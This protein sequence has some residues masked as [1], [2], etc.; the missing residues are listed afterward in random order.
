MTTK[1]GTI[2]VGV[3][4]SDQSLRALSWAVEQCAAEHRTLTLVHAVHVVSPAYLDAAIVYQP[5]AETLL[6]AE[7]QQVLDAAAAE[8]ERLAPGIEVDEVLS[9]ADPRLVLI[10]LSRDA[11]MVVL[12]SRG[13]GQVRSLLLGSVGTALAKH[14]QCPVVIHRPGNPGL[15]RNGVVVGVDASAESQGVL[16]FAYQEASW[17]DLPLTLLHCSWDAQADALGAYLVADSVVGLETERLAVAEAIAGMAEKY[18]DV[19]T[20]TEIVRGLPQEALLR[21]GERMDLIVVGAHVPGHARHR[22]FG[23]V[24]A[25]VVEHASCAVAVVPAG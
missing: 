9:V 19:R 11:T 7:G 24:A 17:R 1:P 25:S 3:D 10:E 13:R 4:A 16:E 23:S 21:A 12:G 5:D 20:T 6:R 14:A 15:V 18:P 8:V 2:V 22:L